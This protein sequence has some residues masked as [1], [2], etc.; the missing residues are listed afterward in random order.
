M[1]RLLYPPELDRQ[2]AAHPFDPAIEGARYGLAREVSIAIW[3]RVCAEATDATG[4]ADLEQAQRRFHEIAA[5]IAAR[6][7]RLH[8]D[9]GRLT[10]VGVEIG[11]DSRAMPGA[12]Q[13]AVRVPGRETL[14]AAEARRWRHLDTAAIQRDDEAGLTTSR[15][16]PDADEVRQAIAALHVP[17]PPE[18][19]VPA[20]ATRPRPTMSLLFRRATTF[21]EGAVDEAAG[22]IDRSER[23]HEGPGRQRAFEDRVARTF[24]DAARGIPVRDDDGQARGAEAA[25][26]GGAVFLGRRGGADEALRVGHELAHAI[27]QRRGMDSDRRIS[28]SQRGALEAEAERA[29]H[30]FA[31]GLPFRVEGAAPARTAL[32]RGGPEEVDG[33]ELEGAVTLDGDTPPSGLPSGAT[34]DG[35]E[36]PDRAI[37]GTGS[38]GDAPSRGDAGGADAHGGPDSHGRGKSHGA[39]AHG[40]AKSS[41]D[42]GHGGPHAAANSHGAHA[43]T[44]AH[45]DEAH[46]GA[47]HPKPGLGTPGAGPG[48]HDHPSHAKAPTGPAANS[49]PASPQQRVGPQVNRRPSVDRGAGHTPNTD[50]QQNLPPRPPGVPPGTPPPGPANAAAAL[51]KIASARATAPRHDS[52]EAGAGHA[53][54][55]HKAMHPKAPTSRL[56]RHAPLTRPAS[57][58][59]APA[60]R[61]A[62][63][64]PVIPG[65]GPSIAGPRIADAVARLRT[66]LAEAMGIAGSPVRFAESPAPTGDIK[67][68]ASD[69]AA[70]E[71]PAAMLGNVDADAPPSGIRPDPGA[72]AERAAR[73]RAQARQLVD[74]LMRRGAQRVQGVA[75]L[76]ATVAQ[77]VQPALEAAHATISTRVTQSESI[78]RAA[79]TA[80]RTRITS[81]AAQTRGTIAG[82]HQQATAAVRAAT[83]A[84]RAT[85][86]TGYATAL[87]TTI[88]R[89]QQEIGHVQQIYTEYDP[90][91]RAVGPRVGGEATSHAA[92]RAATWRSQFDGESDFWDGPLHDNRLRARADTATAVGDAYRSGLADEANKQADAAG[93]GQ[94]KDIDNVHAAGRQVREQLGQ[95]HTQTQEALAAGERQALEAAQHTV[96]AILATLE[97]QADGALHSLVDQ[98]ITLLHGVRQTGQSQRRAIDDAG[99][100]AVASLQQSLAAAAGGL[101]QTLTEL[102]AHLDGQ[103]APDPRALAEALRHVGAQLDESAAQAVASAD[104]GAASAIQATNTQ[105]AQAVQGLVEASH[106]GMEA[107]TAAGAGFVQRAAHSQASA[108]T[109]FSQLSTGHRTN[110]SQA[111]TS[112]TQ[113]FTQQVA[114][115]ATMFEQLEHSLR[116]GFDQSLRGL[117][118]GLRGALGKLD[119]DI[120]READKAA[121]QVQPRWKSVLKVVLAIAIVLVVAIVVGPAVVGFVGAAAGA[122]GASAGAASVIGAVVGGAVVG[123][124]AGAVNQMGNNLI[125]NRPVM[126]GVGHAAIMGAV[127]GAVGGGAGA[128]GSAL[129]RGG[130]TL[131]GLAVRVGGNMVGAF[132]G[133]VAA[134]VATGRKIDWRAAA[135][136]AAVAGVFSLGAEGLGA[137]A[138]A[139]AAGRFGRLGAFAGRVG[140][141]VSGWQRTFG[142]YGARAG[143][144]VGSRM[145]MGI[146]SVRD[147]L[148]NEGSSSANRLGPQPG[149]VDL[150]DPR[151]REH[152]IE[153]EGVPGEG[154][155]RHAYGGGEPSRYDANGRFRPKSEFPPEWSNERILTNASD[156]ATDPTAYASPNNPNNPASGAN[157]VFYGVRDG[158]L[159]QV[160]VSP[161]GR[162]VTAYPV[163]QATVRVPGGPP[164]AT[165]VITSPT[166]I[167][168][169]PALPSHPILPPPTQGGDEHRDPAETPP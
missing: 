38:H 3:E 98:Q 118:E 62:A 1:T 124:G 132:G 148:G 40:H 9:V 27:Q 61:A 112:A 150:T 94:A 97:Q 153:G 80:A 42:I 165:T 104:R 141:T 24:G 69:G 71:A 79:V 157:R 143:G 49:P 120:N 166:P 39:E 130:S 17:L 125:D 105:T 158:V 21:P 116:A 87:I 68:P 2:R 102:H 133:Q 31:A 109:A 82:G 35:A 7:G 32:F 14:I 78:I 168:A 30:A 25:T 152:I 46:A 44:A 11:G 156:V 67:A 73:R 131:A 127:T 103:P 96:D 65:A 123:A 36:L 5:K 75:G 15:E 90:R 52:P 126:E 6:G 137:F 167:R 151:G 144:F 147:A 48:A 92:K 13:L 70:A 95:T 19:P 4:A 164:G 45:R 134:D 58:P 66:S 63:M 18:Q 100:G 101:R 83:A 55:L 128:W 161:T 160:V 28:R 34:L 59:L 115:M 135:T 64:M 106:A 139:G 108:Q 23:G 159:M 37:H 22:T 163:N 142:A 10:R 91:Y 154:R 93:A 111:A 140:D 85:E 110:S 169:N 26:V 89:E 77:R 56:P 8:P 50:A 146:D 20:A 145:Q 99:R 121:A 33:D 43:G 29:G 129:S 88:D 113:A 84:A 119:P 72:A 57:P 47:S 81:S 107:A 136:G 53:A 149:G 162:I 76:G 86:A 114:G 12:P 155:G 117:E 122:L 54:A 16:R 138:R 41:A 74:E 60:P 51:P